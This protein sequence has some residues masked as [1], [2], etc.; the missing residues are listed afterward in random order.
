MFFCAIAA[1]SAVFTKAEFERSYNEVDNQSVLSELISVI[2]TEE[3]DS[4]VAY[5]C[6]PKFYILQD[7][8]P[9]YRF[10]ALQDKQASVSLS[11]MKM[12]R[13]TFSEKT[14]KWI[15]FEGNPDI[16]YITDILKNNYTVIRKS[17]DP[18]LRREIYL[19]SRK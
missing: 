6:H 17:Y 10:F 5:N 14:A 18:E 11:M 7:I 1:G 9:C 13:T 15:L 2:P 8:Q 19:Y 16:S 4:I 3:K 12:L